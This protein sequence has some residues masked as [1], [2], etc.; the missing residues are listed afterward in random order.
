MLRDSQ[1]LFPFRSRK[2]SVGYEYIV[3]MVHA[4]TIPLAT[5][6]IIRESD[7]EQHGQ[8]DSTTCLGILPD[9]LFEFNNPG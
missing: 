8:A 3:V 9:I 4:C 1:P 7:H 6:S 2:T 5:A